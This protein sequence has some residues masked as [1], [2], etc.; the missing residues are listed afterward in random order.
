MFTFSAALSFSE[1]PQRNQKYIINSVVDF[2]FLF[3]FI[4][5]VRKKI[6]FDWIL[7]FNQQFTKEYPQTFCNYCDYFEQHLQT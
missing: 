2:L 3:F 7:S 4:I 1:L 5:F 6:Y